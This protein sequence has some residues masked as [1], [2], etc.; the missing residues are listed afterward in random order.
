MHGFLLHACVC[1]GGHSDVEICNLIASVALAQTGVAM[2]VADIGQIAFV[3][4]Q[5]N[6]EWGPLHGQTLTDDQYFGAWGRAWYAL[7]DASY[8]DAGNA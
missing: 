5:L 3:S 2:Q 7:G 1:R 8:A 6:A 4:S